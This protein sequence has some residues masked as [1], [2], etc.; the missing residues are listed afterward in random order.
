[1]RCFC[2]RVDPAATP[3]FTHLPGHCIAWLK[4]SL[5]LINVHERARKVANHSHY[6]LIIDGQSPKILIKC[7]KAG[8][9]YV[10]VLAVSFV[11]C[12]TFLVAVN[13]AI[14]VFFWFVELTTT[15]LIAA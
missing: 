15:A 10:A 4:V 7:P 12:V 13:N 5:T 14:T 1:M 9:P 8:V 11:T 2:S 6:L 3:I